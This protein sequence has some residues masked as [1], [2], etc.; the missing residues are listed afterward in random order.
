MFWTPKNIKQLMCYD[1]LEPI[2][3]FRFDE[4]I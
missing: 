3:Q 2:S 1:Y 4:F